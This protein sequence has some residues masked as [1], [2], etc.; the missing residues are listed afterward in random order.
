MQEL[1]ALIEA[2]TEK[3]Y[4]VSDTLIS[5][6]LAHALKD[7]AQTR[8]HIGDF[9]E[10][11]VGRQLTKRLDERIRGDLTSWIEGDMANHS[12]ALQQYLKFLDNLKDQL[13][14]IFYLGI[15]SYEGHFACY[16]EGAFYRKHVD[17]HRGRGLRRLSV[18]LYLSDMSNDDGGEVVIYH[19]QKQDVEVTRIRPKLGR[20][21]IFLSED[22]PHE[23]LPAY[24]ARLSLTGWLR[25]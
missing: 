11:K 13:N 8:F 17:Q 5:N 1:D 7:E 25:A 3:R 14:P 18:I 16:D 19:H 22:L 15:R 12:L 6:E 20:L 4:Y 23:V 10:A 24:K 2:L 21:L 9:Q